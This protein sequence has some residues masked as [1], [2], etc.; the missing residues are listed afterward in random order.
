[1]VDDFHLTRMGARHY[2]R[3]M[4]GILEELRE[5]NQQLGL[6]IA[7][8]ALKSGVELDIDICSIINK[9]SKESDNG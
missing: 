7:I 1:M 3:T 2:E 6:L 4:P 5:L 8:Y 9:A